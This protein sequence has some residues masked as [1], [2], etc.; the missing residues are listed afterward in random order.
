MLIGELRYQ[1]SLLT[2]TQNRVTLSVSFVDWLRFSV[3]HEVSCGKRRYLLLIDTE[4]VTLG[5]G[6]TLN[7]LIVFY[8][9]ECAL[10]LLRHGHRYQ[11]VGQTWCRQGG[12]L[13]SHVRQRAFHNELASG[14]QQL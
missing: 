3:M 4:P 7:P 11:L 12:W 9:G 1:A 6:C 14:T 8:V 5:S 10:H 2:H 13:A